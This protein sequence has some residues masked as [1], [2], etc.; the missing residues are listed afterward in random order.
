[1]RTIT[2]AYQ[3]LCTTTVRG[4]AAARMKR[5]TL[6]GLRISRRASKKGRLTWMRCG[7]ILIAVCLLFLATRKINHRARQRGVVDDLDYPRALPRFFLPYSSLLW[8]C[9][10]PVAL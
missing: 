1:K 8:V 6:I 7:A 5:T 9:G 4:G 2:G 3:E 10:W